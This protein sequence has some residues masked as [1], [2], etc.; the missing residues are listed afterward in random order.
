QTADSNT[1]TFSYHCNV[2]DIAVRAS[3]SSRLDASSYGT[4]IYAPSVPIFPRADLRGCDFRTHGRSIRPDSRDENFA[5][6]APRNS[7]EG[8][9]RNR[10]GSPCDTECPGRRGNLP[11]VGASN[12]RG[13]NDSQHEPSVERGSWVRF[14][15]SHVFHGR[16]S[17]AEQT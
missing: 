17:T 5:P 13:P 10:G 3:N 1:P 7:Q 2:R 12:R 15:Q 6:E 9:P 8:R 16:I 4:A 14:A 11:C